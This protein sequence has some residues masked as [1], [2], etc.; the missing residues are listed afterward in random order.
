MGDYQSSASNVGEYDDEGS[1]FDPRNNTGELVCQH[2]RD[3]GSYESHYLEGKLKVREDMIVTT[4]RHLDD[5]HALVAENC[6]RAT[7]AQDSLGGEFSIT[8]FQTVREGVTMMKS[9]YQHLL[10][11]RDYL[12]V[13]GEMY[14]GALKE[15][16]NEVDRLTHEFVSTHGFLKSTQMALQGLE[17]RIEQLLESIQVS[18]TSISVGSQSFASSISQGDVSDIDDLLESHELVRHP[19]PKMIVERR[20]LE[21]IEGVHVSHEPPFLESSKAVEHAH[22]DSRSRDNLDVDTSMWD[23]GLDDTSDEDTSIQGLEPVDT[24]GLS[25]TAI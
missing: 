15:K 8:N 7:M 16:V 23:P 11:D 25:D 19:R 22:A 12:L 13:I 21:T 5:T 9:N 3:V 18:T 6:W 4:M 20:D 10:M 1:I 24:H 14:H 17:S 2:G